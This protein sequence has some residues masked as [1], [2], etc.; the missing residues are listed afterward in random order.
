M[1]SRLIQLLALS[2]LLLPGLAGCSNE[3]DYKR[4]GCNVF[5]VCFDTLRADHLGC[6]GYPRETSPNID[7]F[8]RDCVF[9]ETAIA[10]ASST[11]PSHASI[12]T[13]Q[14][15]ATHG[16]YGGTEYILGERSVT[17]AEIM[18]E[19]GYKT[20]SYNSGGF[21]RA[22]WGLAQGF[23]LYDSTKTGPF[24][25]T[26][27]A[28]IDWLNENSGEKFFIFMHTY[29]VHHPYQPERRFLELFE[30]SYD[31][32]LDEHIS[33]P[34]LKDI[35]AGKL[36]ITPEDAQH[37]IN[38]YDAEI[39]SMDD[40]FGHFLAYLKEEGLYEDSLIIVFSDHG[41]ELGEHGFMGWHSHTIF[42]ELIHVPLL[43]KFPDLNFKGTRLEGLVRTIDI[44]PTMLDVLDI[45][46][47][48]DFDGISLMKSIQD[49]KV[50]PLMSMTQMG[51]KHAAIRTQRWKL[52][53]K[54]LFDLEN[55]PAETMDSSPSNFQIKERLQM[56]LDEYMKSRTENKAELLD[57]D[58][59]T[60]EELR[61]LGYV[62]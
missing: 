9:F 3:V 60:M 59:E 39:R 43:I 20:I 1:G 30:E 21:V 42:E 41:E 40:S 28:T 29:E 32:Q 15:V 56:M 37:I 58:E 18:K 36:E 48:N 33:I 13:A 4:P 19:H 14:N 49:E 22:I 52:F 57:V 27:N 6:Y 53:N 16:T 46:P 10:Q 50:E 7:A 17:I 35:N 61:R 12:F 31:G 25:T 11:K 54:R 2:C 24:K 8:T 51:E 23:D 38:C 62:D 34:V 26:V 44:I 47:L 55:D 45:E 5:F